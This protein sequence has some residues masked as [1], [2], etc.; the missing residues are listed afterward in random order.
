M[1]QRSATE[2]ADPLPNPYADPELCVKLPS[3][4]CHW[5]YERT[6]TYVYTICVMLLILNNYYRIQHNTNYVKKLMEDNCPID[7]TLRFLGV[8]CSIVF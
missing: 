5:L 8:C 3:D 1:M 7:E 2:D 4:L 6:T